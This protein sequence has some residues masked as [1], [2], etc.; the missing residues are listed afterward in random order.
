MIGRL[1]VV[2]MILI[3]VARDGVVETVAGLILLGI[4]F[5]ITDGMFDW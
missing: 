3:C 2:I 5:Y 1:I 4:I